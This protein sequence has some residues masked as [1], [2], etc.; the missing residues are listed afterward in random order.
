[1]VEPKS[2]LYNQR[3]RFCL[4]YKS[5]K[6][7]NVKECNEPARQSNSR[8]HNNTC[9][10]GLSIANLFLGAHNSAISENKMFATLL[11]RAFLQLESIAAWSFVRQWGTCSIRRRQTTLPNLAQATKCYDHDTGAIFSY[12]YIYI[13]IL[14]KLYRN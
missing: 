6:S 1:M 14:G 3:E 2:I 5:S 13:Y 10:D 11:L 4:A 12:I 7:R 9:V 8:D